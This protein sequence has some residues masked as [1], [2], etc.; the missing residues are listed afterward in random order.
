MKHFFTL[1]L[2]NYTL[3]IAIGFAIAGMFPGPVDLDSFFDPRYQIAALLV[4]PFLE[5][6]VFQVL[7]IELVQSLPASLSIRTKSCASIVISAVL[8][9]ALHYRF[10]GPFNAYSFGVVGGLIFPVAYLLW[11]PG[12]RK[13]AFFNTWVLHVASNALLL[14]SFAY[15]HRVTMT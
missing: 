11:R 13:V 5:T 8:F 12:G 7:L 9:F 6:L 4:L 14:L 3:S 10:N 1:L 2:L 15:F